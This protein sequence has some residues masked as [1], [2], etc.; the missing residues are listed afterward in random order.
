VILKRKI[1]ISLL[2]IFY[3]RNFSTEPRISASAHQQLLLLLADRSQP[4]TE[5]DEDPCILVIIDR[6]HLLTSQL[7]FCPLGILP[8]KEARSSGAVAAK[9]VVLVSSGSS[10][11]HA[12]WIPRNPAP[13]LHARLCM[14]R[15]SPET[16]MEDA[17]SRSTRCSSGCLDNALSHAAIGCHDGS[18]LVVPLGRANK[19]A[20]WVASLLNS[21]LQLSARNVLT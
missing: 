7:F 19:S 2:G 8:K 13:H 4:S 17:V 12:P 20:T 3:F 15:R 21:G 10:F 1:R 6:L 11:K 14:H 5:H 9:E 18:S 16:R